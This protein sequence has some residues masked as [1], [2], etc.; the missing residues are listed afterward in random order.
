MG[1]A[2]SCQHIMSA[3]CGNAKRAS[4]RNCF[5]CA[6]QHASALHQAQCTEHDLDQL[7][8]HH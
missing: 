6:G 1:E 2:H 4:T 3:L 5:V 7:C 8:S